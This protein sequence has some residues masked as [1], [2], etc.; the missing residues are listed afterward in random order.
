MQN[1]AATNSLFGK[2]GENNSALFS[3]PQ[4]KSESNNN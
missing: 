4:K 1:L 3:N 2:F